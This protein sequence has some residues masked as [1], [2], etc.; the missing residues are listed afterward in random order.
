MIYVKE[1]TDKKD[2][3]LLA[4]TVIIVSKKKKKA[5][6]YQLKHRGGE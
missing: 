1:S 2:V 4:Q 3:T 5:L 6:G